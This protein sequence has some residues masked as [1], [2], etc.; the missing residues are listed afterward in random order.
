VEQGQA[1]VVRL[2]LLLMITELF[3]IK[4]TKEKTLDSIG[5]RVQEIIVYTF[6]VV[7]VELY[8]LGCGVL[9]VVEVD[10]VVQMVVQV[11]FHMERFRFKVLGFLKVV[12]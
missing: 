8:T 9:Q 7:Q 6:V 5:L 3:S 4:H 12:G 2:D 11:V 1:E 10:K